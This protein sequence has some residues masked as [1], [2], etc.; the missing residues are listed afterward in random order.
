M[1]GNTGST[2]APFSLHQLC[3]ELREPPPY[4]GQQDWGEAQSPLAAGL[5]LARLPL[6]FRL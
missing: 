2:E 3:E 5:A 6:R 4:N 1:A